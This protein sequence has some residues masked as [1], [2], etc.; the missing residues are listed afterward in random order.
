MACGRC[1]RGD[2]LYWL[3]PLHHSLLPW[4]PPLL[5]DAAPS[6]AVAVETAST[7]WCRSITRC[8]RG[9]RLYWLM[10]LHHSLL[11]WRPP[12]L[13]D[14]APSLAVAVET[15]S[16]G[17][18]RSITRCCRGDRLYWLMPLHHSL[19]PW[20][21][22]LLVDVAPSLAVAVETASTGWC[23]CLASPTSCRS[24]ASWTAP[25]WRT[26]SETAPHTHRVQR[27]SRSDVIA[28]VPGYQPAW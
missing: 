22:P 17:W 5:V 18:C 8:C 11:P 9:D 12:L 16:T 2:R 20:R 26:P 21:P 19:L 15:A 7:G 3:M 4:R 23:R 24:T 10:P 14:A 6:L 27:R 1:C 13:V 28:V 25:G